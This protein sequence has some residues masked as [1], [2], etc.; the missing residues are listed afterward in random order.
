MKDISVKGG[1][2]GK[3]GTSCIVHGGAAGLISG[4][5]FSPRFQQQLS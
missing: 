1:G 5:D 4:L 3:R 2:G